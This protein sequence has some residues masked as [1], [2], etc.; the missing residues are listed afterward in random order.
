MPA[1]ASPAGYDFIRRLVFSSVAS[2]VHLLGLLF[3]ATAYL[4]LIVGDQLRLTFGERMSA[5]PSHSLHCGRARFE[6]CLLVP[7]FLLIPYRLGVLECV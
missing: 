6:T 5:V 4:D 2:F 3:G 1:T 7:E